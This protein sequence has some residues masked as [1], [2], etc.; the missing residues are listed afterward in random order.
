MVHLTYITQGINLAD[1]FSAP[2]C[3]LRYAMKAKRKR[4]LEGPSSAFRKAMQH[5]SVYILFEQLSYIR[6]I[7]IRFLHAVLH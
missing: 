6:F 4:L 3:R 5:T 1:M 7:Q 2:S